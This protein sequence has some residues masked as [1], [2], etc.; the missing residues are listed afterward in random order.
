MKIVLFHLNLAT[1]GGE[2][3]TFAAWSVT[4]DMQT[5]LSIVMLKIRAKNGPARYLS[6]N[7]IFMKDRMFSML[8]GFHKENTWVPG[9]ILWNN[10]FFQFQLELLLITPQHYSFR[11]YTFVVCPL[12]LDFVLRPSRSQALILIRHVGYECAQ[13]QG[14]G[15]AASWTWKLG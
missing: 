1:F 8:G 3:F 10:W 9:G 14:V 2:V 12:T 6:F 7:T 5:H 15:Q 4:C 13:P 11:V